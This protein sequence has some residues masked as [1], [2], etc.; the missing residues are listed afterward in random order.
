MCVALAGFASVT[1]ET[2]VNICR[3]PGNIWWLD[4]WLVDNAAS[5]R[6]DHHHK[7]GW[8]PSSKSNHAL[9]YALE[10]GPVSVKANKRALENEHDIFLLTVP[11][12]NINT[13]FG[14]CLPVLRGLLYQCHPHAFGPCA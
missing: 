12:V 14:A 6:P 4:Y 1:P 10:R 9:L 3:G 7:L 11:A 13:A 2:S 8:I 5:L